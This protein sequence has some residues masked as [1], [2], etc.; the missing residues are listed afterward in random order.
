MY[1]LF[2]V[3]FVLLLMRKAI[4]NIIICSCTHVGSYCE[5]MFFVIIWKKVYTASI[6]RLLNY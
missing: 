3:L 1:L 2:V 4:H 5:I 6:T